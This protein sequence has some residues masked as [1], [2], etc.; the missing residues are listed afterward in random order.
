MK[1][2]TDRIRLVLFGIAVSILGVISPSKTL[3]ILHRVLD[4][5]ED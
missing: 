5:H 1:F 3:Q 2:I 4:K